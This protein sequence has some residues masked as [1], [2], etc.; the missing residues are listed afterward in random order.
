MFEPFYTTKTIGEGTGLGL[1]L[2]HGIVRDHDGDITV[3]S[4][5]GRG[6]TFTIR[7]PAIADTPRFDD[8]RSSAS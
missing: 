2:V 5:V 7:L 6:T 1:P 3:D 4:V 8:L